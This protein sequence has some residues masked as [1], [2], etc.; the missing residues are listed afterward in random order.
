ME[1]LGLAST[2][3]CP[4]API[5]PCF[6][7]PN[8]LYGPVTCLQYGGPVTC[9]APERRKRRRRGDEATKAASQRRG[10]TLKCLEAKARIL[11]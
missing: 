2:M 3:P 1:G 10:N 8:R 6:C 11:L 9:S 4:C 7:R 5:P